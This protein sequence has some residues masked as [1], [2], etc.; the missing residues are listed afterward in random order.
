MPTAWGM[1][2][3]FLRILVKLTNVKLIILKNSRNLRNSANTLSRMFLMT[4]SKSSKIS[5]SS[6]SQ[7]NV[8]GY[9]FENRDCKF[10]K[11]V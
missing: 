2:S 10:C 4:K 8:A 11:K 5:K 7:E 6:I 1:I 3:K 9:R